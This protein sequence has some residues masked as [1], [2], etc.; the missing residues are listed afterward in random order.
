[1]QYL[2]EGILSD[3]RIALDENEMTADLIRDINTLS[4]NDIIR[5]KVVD[6]VRTV[7]LNA[8]ADLMGDAPSIA[9]EITWKGNVATLPLPDDFLRLVIFKMSDWT[10]PVLAAI[11]DS[12]PTYLQLQCKWAGVRGNDERPIVAV[13]QSPEGYRLEAYGSKDET[14]QIEMA[15]YNPVPQIEEN[16]I[17]FCKLLY[18]AVIYQTAGLTAAT[19]GEERATTL[20]ELSKSYWTK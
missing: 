9:S 6:A 12:S 19:F 17:S 4:L 5:Q 13:V 7:S 2:L 11:T 1:M 14:A 3:V 20:I 18:P 15:K 10:I 8:S 16:K